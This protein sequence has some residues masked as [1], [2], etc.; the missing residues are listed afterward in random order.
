MPTSLS[1][2][3]RFLSS[4]GVFALPALGLCLPRAF[5]QAREL[6]PLAEIALDRSEP[7]L[8]RGELSAEQAVVPVDGGFARLTTY[9]RSFPGPLL[10]VRRGETVQLRFSNRLAEE[11]NLHFH[12]MNIPPVRRADNIWIHVPKGEAFEYAF[13]VSQRDAGLHWYHPH[14]HGKM[15]RQMFAGLTGAILVEDPPEIADALRGIDDRICVLKD[16]TLQGEDVEPHRHLEWPVGKEGAQ[17]LV[18]GV[19]APMVR[20]RSTLVRLRLLNA[21]NARYWRLRLTADQPFSIIAE[22]GYFLGAPIETEELL[23]V[24]GGRAEILVDLAGREH[25][26]MWYHPAPRRGHAFTAVQ[27]LLHVEPRADATPVVHPARLGV[28]PVFDETTVVQQ[29]SVVLSLLNIC[30]QFFRED[31]V[32]IH[33]RAGS[34]EIWRVN[35]VD[36]M[37]HTFHLHTWHFHVLS[38]NDEAPAHDALRDTVNV[39]PGDVLRLGVDFKEHRGRTLYHC[40]MAEHSDKGMMAVIQVD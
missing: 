20:A 28:V 25:V 27:P 2:R 12:G 32:D 19:R 9:N 33:A 31:R 36:L 11:T 23:L 17:L 4:A 34:R 37:D 24:P 15:A 1:R 30:S 3:R 14:I 8:A 5:A 6:P 29:R 38:V 10:R 21:S 13:T 18:N 7:G 26:T 35:N 16:I 39:R 22:D 40:H